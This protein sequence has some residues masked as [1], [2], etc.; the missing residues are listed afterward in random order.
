[1]LSDSRVLSTV[2]ALEGRSHDRLE[3]DRVHGPHGRFLVGVVRNGQL[4]LA[5]AEYD[6]PRRMNS[7]ADVSSRFGNPRHPV[8]RHSAT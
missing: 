1:M 8:S 5:H 2:I 6:R 4:V 7:S 3:L